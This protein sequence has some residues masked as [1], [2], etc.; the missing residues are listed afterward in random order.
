MSF[1]SSAKSIFVQLSFHICRSLKSNGIKEIISLQF[2]TEFIATD[3]FLTELLHWFK[4]KFFKWVDNPICSK[5]LNT[6]IYEST[7]LSTNPHCSKI[8]LHR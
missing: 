7:E 2:E 4:Y 8:E 3:L 5:C 1:V 6:C